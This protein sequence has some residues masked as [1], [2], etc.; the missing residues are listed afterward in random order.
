M[1]PINAALLAGLLF[2]SS[3]ANAQIKVGTSQAGLDLGLA[4]PL[5]NTD[6]GNG[7]SG[8]FGHTGPAFGFNYLYQFQPIF[9]FGGDYNYKFLGS[10]DY[11]APYG[12]VTVRTSAWTLLA[13]GRADLMP[14]N[15]VRPYGLVGLGLGG[16]SRSLNFARS[17]FNSDNTS[18]GVAFALGGGVDYDVNDD[19]LVGA[20]LRYS[21][22]NTSRSDVGTDSVSSL[23][24]LFKVGYKFGR[25]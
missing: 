15:K 21:I 1:R 20:E 22:I 5:S 13:V 2:V 17:G 9:S 23:D 19:W 14:D 25:Q 8:R 7:D 6:L 12:G 16:A 18:V 3:Q 4:N 24:L 11:P 10:R